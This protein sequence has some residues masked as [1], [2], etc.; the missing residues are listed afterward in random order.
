MLHR[1]RRLNA[2]FSKRLNRFRPLSRRVRRT[3]HLYFP[4]YLQ[5]R[6]AAHASATIRLATC[7]ALRS[8]SAA[9]SRYALKAQRGS[10]ASRTIAEFGSTAR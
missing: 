9:Q 7:S 8:R 1:T 3:A 6:A 4:W 5:A 10:R 2:I